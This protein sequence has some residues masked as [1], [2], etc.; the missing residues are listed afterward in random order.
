ML[1]KKYVRFP[2]VGMVGQG[3]DM[4]MS[5]INISEIIRPP[6]VLPVMSVVSKSKI[7]PLLMHQE[8]NLVMLKKKKIDASPRPCI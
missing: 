4:L 6:F 3:I 8:L 7:N 1:H 2:D 5:E